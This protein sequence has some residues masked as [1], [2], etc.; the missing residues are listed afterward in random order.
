MGLVI[1]QFED[2]DLEVRLGRIEP[3]GFFL[4]VAY[5]ERFVIGVDGFF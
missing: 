5:N 2:G 3:N 4:V 1:E